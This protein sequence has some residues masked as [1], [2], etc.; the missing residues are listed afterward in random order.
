MAVFTEVPGEQVWIVELSD[1]VYVKRFSVPD[2]AFIRTKDTNI[3][4]RFSSPEEAKAFMEGANFTYNIKQ[5]LVTVTV[6][7]GNLVWIK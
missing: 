6:T 1:N 7:V 5:A 2:R 3:A 4:A